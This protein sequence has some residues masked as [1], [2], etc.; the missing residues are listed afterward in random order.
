MSKIYIRFFHH[1]IQ[2][3]NIVIQLIQNIRIIKLLK[4]ILYTFY[5]PINN[6][7]IFSLFV[8]KTNY[9]KIQTSNTYYPTF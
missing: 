2:I 8:F 9:D 4:L 5:V 7:L 3:I 1:K 6:Y